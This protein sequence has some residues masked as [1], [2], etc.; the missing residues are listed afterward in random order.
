[1]WP[2]SRLRSGL[3]SSYVAVYSTLKTD[4]LASTTEADRRII[5]N[6]NGWSHGGDAAID[7]KLY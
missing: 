6:S 7:A 1:M 3:T 2:V 5:A 4:K